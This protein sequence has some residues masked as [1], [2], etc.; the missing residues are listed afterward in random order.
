MEVVKKIKVREEKERIKVAI[1]G[2]RTSFQK[3]VHKLRF[4][5]IEATST[6]VG[7]AV[8]F[9][10]GPNEDVVMEDIR[11]RRRFELITTQY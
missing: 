8:P 4:G 2:K 7:D 6:R 10:F 9:K 3:R 5:T 11:A 1:Q